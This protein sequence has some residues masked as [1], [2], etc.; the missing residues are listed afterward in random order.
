VIGAV[1]VGLLIAACGGSTPRNAAPSRTAVEAAFQG[2]PPALAAIHHQADQLLAGGPAAFHR[3]LAALR[4]HPVV[5]NMWASWCE[6]C[7][8]E[9]PVFQKVA[10]ADGRRI[11][12][13]GIDVSDHNGAAGAFLKKFPVSYP[14]YVDPKKAIQASLRTYNVMPQTFFFDARGREQYDHGGP[15]LTVGSLQRDIKLYLHQ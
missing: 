10:V 8:S 1:A 12:F 5:V 4:G 7:Q 6:P 9:F 2:S 13:V 3:R 14:S 15:Y 11:G